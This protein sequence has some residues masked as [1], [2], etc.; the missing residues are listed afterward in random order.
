MEGEI[1]TLK[2]GQAGLDDNISELR[3]D[4]SRLTGADYE[5]H[6]AAY[7]HRA[8]R[9][10]QGINASVFST[11][12]DKTRLTMLLDEAETHGLKEPMETDELDRADMVLTTDGPTDYL[13]A[14]ISVTI[15]QDDIDRAADRARLL[16]KATSETVTAFAIGTREDENLQKGE[17]Q[18]L[19]IPDRRR[20]A[21]E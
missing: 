2:E 18:V 8:L 6:V 20:P 12:Q 17:V 11:Q 15:Q 4:V 1:N 19:I 5:S 21:T 7:V 14:E 9:R 3:T 13:L 16:A 10:S